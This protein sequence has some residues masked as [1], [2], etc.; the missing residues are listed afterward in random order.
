[1]GYLPSFE[2]EGAIYGRY[3][4]AHKPKA[5]IAVLYEN[6]D[7]GND[8]LPGCSAASASTRRR[9][10]RRR[11]YE[12]TDTDVKSQVAKLR[13]LEGGHVH[14]LRASRPTRSRRSSTPTSSAGTRRSSSARSRSSR[15]S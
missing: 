4:V 3:I 15:R 11:R 2:G 6:S 1:M 14:A 13:R 9:S 8:L 12:V 5:K 7:Y 10:S